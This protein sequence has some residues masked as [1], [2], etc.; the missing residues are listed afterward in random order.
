MH[1]ASSAVLRP[2]RSCC[3][4]MCWCGP[5]VVFWR[6]RPG[7]RRGKV[8]RID[9]KQI[10]VQ[11]NRRKY[12]CHESCFKPFVDPTRLIATSESSSVPTYPFKINA[13][14]FGDDT[15]DPY[16]KSIILSRPLQKITAIPNGTSQNHKKW[17]NILTWGFCLPW[18]QNLYPR[19]PKIHRY[20]WFR[21]EKDRENDKPKL[22]ACICLQVNLDWDFDSIIA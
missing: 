19:E 14:A 10:Y 13:R 6:K 3:S 18:N 15:F 8:V 22:C 11:H 16:F 4:Y 7:S 20:T 21:D 12:S 1:H 2:R 5:G 9:G 17:R